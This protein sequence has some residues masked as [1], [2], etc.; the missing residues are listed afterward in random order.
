MNSRKIH[1]LIGLIL[2]IPMLGWTFTGLMFF[3]KPGYKAAYEQLTL[4]TY[5]LDKSFTIP[6][7]Q[8]WQEVKLI[9]SILGYHL[10]V[11][12][13]DK[14]EHLDPVSF[15]VK[16]FPTSLEYQYLLEDAISKNKERYGN[17]VNITGAHAKTIHGIDIKL[18]WNNFKLSQKG[19]DTKL[20]NLLY[21]IH[22]LQWSPFKGLNQVLGMVGLLLLITLTLMGIK[23][24]I[25]SKK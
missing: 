11:Q 9:K 18:D 25:E 2:I 4:K 1:T 13:A 15:K 3:I 21:K 14:I 10:L 20:I 16:P 24:Y 7:S 5:P 12:S 6:S 8:A 23:L 17:V 22:Y 19:S